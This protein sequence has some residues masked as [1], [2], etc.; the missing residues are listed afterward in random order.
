MNMTGR[1]LLAEM[2]AKT[3]AEFIADRPLTKYYAREALQSI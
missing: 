3:R 1:R 2:H